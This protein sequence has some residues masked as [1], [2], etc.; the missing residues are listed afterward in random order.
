MLKIR[1]IAKI[2]KKRKKK[3]NIKE[4]NKRKKRE[5]NKALSLH[6]LWKILRQTYLHIV[7]FIRFIVLFFAFA[8]FR[9]P[10]PT[11]HRPLSGGLRRPRLLTPMFISSPCDYFARTWRWDFWGLRNVNRTAYRHV[12]QRPGTT[13]NTILTTPT[14]PYLDP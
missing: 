2:R 9:T 10:K 11:S 12:S 4:I 14:M 6:I 5:P 1:K 13:Y 8:P 7:L 3:S